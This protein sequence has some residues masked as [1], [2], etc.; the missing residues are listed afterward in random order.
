MKATIYHN[1]KCSKSRETMK[2]LETEQIKTD[3]ILY[4]KKAMS[5]NEIRNLLNLLSCKPHEIIRK[6]EFLLLGLGIDL[7]DEK[8]VIETIVK[9]PI[10]LER[11]IVIINNRAVIGRPPSNVYKI[12]SK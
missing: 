9:H 12:I 3:I 6:K 10:V 11:P 2:I 5:G 7:L 1:P 4:L 8:L